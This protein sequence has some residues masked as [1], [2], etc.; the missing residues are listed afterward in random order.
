MTTAKRWC[1]S[2]FFIGL[3]ILAIAI[4]VYSLED[5]TITTLPAYLLVISYGLCSL[6]GCGW[7]FFHS[8]LGYS[9]QDIV[10]TGDDLAPT[11]RYR[12]KP[13]KIYGMIGMILAALLFL[14][15]L[16]PVVFLSAGKN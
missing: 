12:G 13:A 15:S 1:K 6:G 11:T 5:Q 7:L 16:L 9:Q 10:V 3:G 14:A 4:V 8:L 2:L